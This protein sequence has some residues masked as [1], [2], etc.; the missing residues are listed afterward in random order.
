MG[1][2]DLLIILNTKRCHYQCHFCQLPAKSSRKLIGGERINDQVD[3]VLSELKHSLSIIDR[4]TLSNEGSVLDSKTLPTEALLTLASVVNELRR[5]RTLVL[6]TRLE[7]IDRN[8]ISEIRNRCSRINIDILT[9]FETS[10]V[11]IRDNILGKR[12]PL[13]LF[14]KGLDSIAELSATLT[15]YVLYKPSPYMT[16]EEAAYDATASIDYLV[17]ECNQRQIPLAV[18]LN[19]MYLAE[20]SKWGVLAKSSKAYRPPRLT[21]IMRIAEK[22][23]QQGVRIYIGLSTEGLDEPGGNYFAREDYTSKLIKY[24]KL[25][26]D[27]KIH[28]FD[29]NAIS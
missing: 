22:K 19:P 9:G 14:L 13:S 4:V 7:F 11:E 18:R 10:N 1:E 6:E 27:R 23:A 17:H 3:F 28:S 29:W 5:V 15:A 25:F 8:V 21:D 20:G 2:N 24:I 16:D 12:E 26:N